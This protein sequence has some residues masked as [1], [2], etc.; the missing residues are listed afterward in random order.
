MIGSYRLRAI[1]N[2]R[3]ILIANGETYRLQI[4]RGF[5]E[6]R[7]HIEFGA[8][9]IRFISS[10]PTQVAALTGIVAVLTLRR[11]S[12]MVTWGRRGWLIWYVIRRIRN[13]AQSISSK[14]N[15]Y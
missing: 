5:T 15:G 11:P 6:L 12:T 9:I 7:P 13:V 4:V 2:K 14:T 3:E 1:N 8:R 10:L